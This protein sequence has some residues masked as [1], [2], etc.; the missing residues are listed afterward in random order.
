MNTYYCVISAIYDSG[1]VIA[2]IIKEN[3]DAKPK[4]TFKSLRDRDIYADYFD[5]IN[6]ANSFLNDTINS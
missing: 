3:H 2:N 4:N 6:D 1:K 5:N